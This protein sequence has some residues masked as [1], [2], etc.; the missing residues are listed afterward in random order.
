MLS[1]QFVKS[2][3]V[4]IVCVCF[5]FFYAGCDVTGTQKKADLVIYSYDRPLQLYA[6]LESVCKY[7]T[8]LGNIE[9]IYRTSQ[10]S[11][12]QAYELV[13]KDFN[14]VIFVKQGDHSYQDFKPL[15][16]QAA[17]S[18]LHDYIIFAVD[19][20]IVKDFINVTVDID[21]LESTKAYGFY[22]RLGK[23]ISYCY[24]VQRA[25]AVPPLRMISSGVYAWKFCEAEHDWGY[26]NTVD[27]T[28]YKKED[29]KPFFEKALYEAP[30]PLES[31][32]SGYAYQV[33][34]RI[35][36]CY[37]QS[38]IVNV[39]LN[40]VQKFFNNIHMGVDI[41]YL[42]HEFN[43]GNKIDINPFFRVA[44]CSP[45]QEYTMTFVPRS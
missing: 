31:R 11:Y 35:G 18:S 41:Q 32:W 29:I 13:K 15:T 25:Q 37:E 16:L 28:L 34:N 5:I 22:Y 6:L 43:E 40:R 45:H 17:F 10:E 19:D 8:G 14:Q 9:V 2:I 23:N 42:L 26:P 36:L 24:T 27:M 33:S 30:N 20:I 12:A 4:S 38:K 7:M 39:P 44:N 1:A 3:V 21:L